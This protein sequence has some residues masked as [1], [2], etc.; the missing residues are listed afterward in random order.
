M[1]VDRLDGTTVIAN[2]GSCWFNLRPSNTEP[3]LRLN[4]EATDPALL[5]HPPRTCPGPGP[6]SSMS[7]SWR[8]GIPSEVLA[9][10]DTLFGTGLGVAQEQLADHGAFLPAALVTT[11]DG[12]LR[13]VVVSPDDLDAEANRS[14]RGQ[15]GRHDRGSVCHAAAGTRRLPRR[16]GD[17][18]HLPARR[19]RRRDP[20]RRG[21]LARASPSPPSSPTITTTMAS[22]ATRTPSWTRR[23]AS[24][25]PIRNPAKK[26]DPRKAR[27]VRT[28]PSSSCRRLRPPP[29]PT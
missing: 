5:R 23:N 24:S 7:A 27:Q 15:R 28:P 4:A 3:F 19:G 11:R 9:D 16:R 2:D 17:Q 22:G 8:D 25:G 6:G 26:P 21:A 13:L 10:I 1:N 14:S 20:D 12:G 29:Q 18:R